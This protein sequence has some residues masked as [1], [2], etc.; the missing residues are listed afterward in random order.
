MP[1]KPCKSCEWCMYTRVRR[2]FLISIHDDYC[3]VNV[4]R[5]FQNYYECEGQAHCS[6]LISIHDNHCKVNIIMSLRVLWARGTFFNI[7]GWIRT[8]DTR[9]CIIY[10]YC[11]PVGRIVALAR[12]ETT[13]IKSIYD[14]Y[15]TV[16]VMKS[17]RIQWARA[18]GPLRLGD[19]PTSTPAD[20]ASWHRT[21]PRRCHVSKLYG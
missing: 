9:N 18:T 6:A 19:P 11:I 20:C 1:F 5:S 7:Q 21:L 13:G 15:C 16:N 12:H 2:G 14:D 10:C 8:T 17:L 4:M 3:T